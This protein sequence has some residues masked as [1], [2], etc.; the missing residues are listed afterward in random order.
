MALDHHEE[1]V[2]IMRNSTCQTANRFHLLGLAELF[3]EL[4]S[5]TDVK[6]HADCAF[7]SSVFV[8][9]RLDVTCVGAVSPFHVKCSRLAHHRAAMRRD[10]QEIAI[11]GFEKF[12][13][14][15]ADDVTRIEADTCEPRAHGGCESKILVDRP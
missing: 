7:A 3:L 14:S 11:A 1:I 15:L 12:R 9:Q 10:R 6:S 5:V 2:E 8:T 4:F 13:Q